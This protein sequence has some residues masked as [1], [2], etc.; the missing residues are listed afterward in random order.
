VATLGLDDFIRQGAL[1]VEW[2]ERAEGQLPGT[3]LALRLIEGA[4]PE[5]RHLEINVPKSWLDRIDSLLP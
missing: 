1:L 2:P 4:E 3:A 5:A